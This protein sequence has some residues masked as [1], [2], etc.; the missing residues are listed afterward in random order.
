[1]SLSREWK[2]NPQN[3]KNIANHTSGQELIVKIYK[4]FLQ[5]K[6]KNK[7]NFKWTKDLTRHFFKKGIQM[8]NEKHTVNDAQ[9]H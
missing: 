5:L 8:A 9:H 6:N 2:G 4:E 3:E 7:T 1:M